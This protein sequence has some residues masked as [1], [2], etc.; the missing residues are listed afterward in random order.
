MGGKKNGYEEEFIN[1]FF[2]PVSQVRVS[3]L[4]NQNILNL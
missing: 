1:V 4:F 3:N 2:M